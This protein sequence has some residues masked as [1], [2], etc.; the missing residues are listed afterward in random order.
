M[1]ISLPEKHFLVSRSHST[2]FGKTQACIHALCFRA[3]V[4]IAAPYSWSVHCEHKF[5]NI[6]CRG[7]CCLPQFAALPSSF[8][9]ICSQENSKQH[10]CL[11][12]LAGDRFEGFSCCHLFPCTIRKFLY[13]TLFSTLKILFVLSKGKPSGS[14]VY[15]D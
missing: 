15:S 1:C 3:C 11:H 14:G 10:C 12:D 2:S 4:G 7:V 5:L 9:F 13:L 6:L 8:W